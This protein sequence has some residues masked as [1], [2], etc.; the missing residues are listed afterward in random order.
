MKKMN[1]S[2]KMLAALLMAGAAMTA[3]TNDDTIAEEQQP[4]NEVKTYNVVINASKGGD[5]ATTRALGF[6]GTALKTTWTTGDAVRVVN[7][8][9]TQ[10]GTLYAES[11]GES[12]KLKGTVSGTV[13]N[14]DTWT[15]KYG[16]QPYNNQGNGTLEAI[17]TYDGAEATVNVTDASTTNITTS[18]A[19][20]VNQQAIIKFTLSDK[21]QPTRKMNVSELTIENMTGN[22][23]V[24]PT[25]ATW[26]TNGD[27]VIYMAFRGGIKK[28]TA[29]LGGET[30][31]YTPGSNTLVNGKYYTINVA[32]RNS[33]AATSKALSA[34]T[35]SEVGWRLGKDGVAYSPT[36]TLPDAAKPIAAIIAYV[37]TPGSVDASSTTYRGLAIALNDCQNGGVYRDYAQRYM[38]KYYDYT[39]DYPTSVCGE[40][41]GNFDAAINNL[42]GIART[43]YLTSHGHSHPAATAAQSNDGTAVPSGVT[44][45]WFLPSLGQW[46]LI[47][48][49]LSGSN[50]S[51]I[52]WPSGSPSSQKRTEI[53]RDKINPK[54]VDFGEG[55]CDRCYWT[56]NESMY[57]YESTPW[58]WHYEPNRGWAGYRN[59]SNLS[60]G[61]LYADWCVRSVLAF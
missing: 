11:D 18:D 47:V 33:N 51:I 57:T 8:S 60:Y 56:C 20:F 19:D 35:S 23:T 59:A 24:N 25:S 9:S 39:G 36:G 31:T 17:S 61:R 29:T 55:F 12:T 16:V 34:V 27:G 3:C 49:G 21:D 14:G 52:E 42:N 28:V 46:Q 45:G 6:D 7:S 37:G 13:N 54:L 10:I 58:A 32:L 30:Y 15:L 44:S 41:A 1:V 40:D 38:Y 43:T 50:Q 5:E 48:R 4:I 26:S 22:A 53:A 2:I